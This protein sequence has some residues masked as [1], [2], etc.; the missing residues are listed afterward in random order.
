MKDFM[1]MA[2]VLLICVVGIVVPVLG[3]AYLVDNGMPVPETGLGVAVLTAGVSIVASGFAM[4]KLF[5]G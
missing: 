5:R 2:R 1:G 4:L 3:F